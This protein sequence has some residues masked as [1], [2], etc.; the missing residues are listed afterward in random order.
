MRTRVRALLYRVFSKEFKLACQFLYGQTEFISIGV[1]TGIPQEIPLI[2]YFPEDKQEQLTY[3]LESKDRETR[4]LGI[5][6]IRL[7]A[8]ECI[9]KHSRGLVEKSF[10]KLI[11]L[12]SHTHELE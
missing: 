5:E 8:L 9:K 7:K 11:Q 3:M 4:R 1:V 6:M 2:K 12:I 10:G